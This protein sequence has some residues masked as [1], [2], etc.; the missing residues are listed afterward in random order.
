MKLDSKYADYFPEYSNY[1]GGALILLKS[2][3]GIIKS[4]KLFSDKLTAWLLEAVF[5]QSQCHMSKYYKYS[6]YG[7]K[8]VVLSYVY[9]CV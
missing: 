1:F 2:M 8:I 6:L 3:H 9:D 4:G 5:I 7:S